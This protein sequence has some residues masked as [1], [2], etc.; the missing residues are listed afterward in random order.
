M[1]VEY[2]NP[3]ISSTIKVFSTM[4]GVELTRGQIYAKAASNPECEVSGIVGLSGKAQGTI[5][6]SL[7]RSTAIAVT[8]KLLGERPPEINADVVDAVGELA[9]MVV[10]GA[11]AQLEKFEL[12]LTIPTVIA[13]KCFCV[14]FPSN[15]L[16][17]CI[18]F[19]SPWGP[20]TVEVG[21]VERE[22]DGSM[23]RR[24]ERKLM[25]V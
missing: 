11:K 23:D 18:P 4:L 1:K 17:I 13:G 10:G 16:P 21:F 15:T 6:L 7:T 9:N 8:E 12:S 14:E 20:L 5:V 3:F 24:Q 19:D 2:I 22:I 25:G